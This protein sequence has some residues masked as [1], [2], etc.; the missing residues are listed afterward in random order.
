MVASFGLALVRHCSLYYLLGQVCHLKYPQA[1]LIIFVYDWCS[2]VITRNRKLVSNKRRV[3]S[4]TERDLATGYWSQS[5]APKIA[6]FKIDIHDV[7]RIRFQFVA[8]IRI[9]KILRITV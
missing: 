6:S 8:N 5:D 7:A 2:D 9:K 1:V 4:V 3:I